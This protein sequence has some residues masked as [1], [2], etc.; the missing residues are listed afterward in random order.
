MRQENREHFVLAFTCLLSCVFRLCLLFD[1]PQDVLFMLKM[2][3]RGPRT[4]DRHCFCPLKFMI[5]GGIWQ[6]PH[7]TYTMYNNIHTTELMFELCYMGVLLSVKRNG[8]NKNA[9]WRILY[10]RIKVCISSC[11]FKAPNIKFYS[12]KIACTP[13]SPQSTVNLSFHKKA[14]LKRIHS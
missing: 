11:R 12:E 9:S 8:K 5:P 10:S 7:I 13:Q 14:T 3:W 2:L 4:T 6:Y 1:Y